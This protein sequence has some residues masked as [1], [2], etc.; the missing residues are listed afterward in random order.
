MAPGTASL[1]L[2]SGKEPSGEDV[3]DPGY[4]KREGRRD[5]AVQVNHPVDDHHAVAIGGDLPSTTSSKS[6]CHASRPRVFAA[7]YPPTADTTRCTE[8]TTGCLP[9]CAR[10][11]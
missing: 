5:P 6:A 2:T 4:R 8:E 3:C 1:F 9:R 11:C 10:S 7:Q